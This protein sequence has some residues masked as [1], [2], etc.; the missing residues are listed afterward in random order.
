MSLDD[1]LAEVY[2][3]RIEFVTMRP[4]DSQF[5]LLERRVVVTGPPELVQ[6]AQTGTLDTLDELVKLLADPERA[7]AAEVLLAAMTRQEEKIVDNYAAHPDEWGRVMGERAYQRWG[8]WLKENRG[9][10]AWDE[11]SKTFTEI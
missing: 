9:K 7:W 10:L 5:A 6:L 1:V 8:N 11:V 3:G 4:P 2:N